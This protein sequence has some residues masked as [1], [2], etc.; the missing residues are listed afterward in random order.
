LL[1]FIE[2]GLQHPDGWRFADNAGIWSEVAHPRPH[3]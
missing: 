1:A 3:V 2:P